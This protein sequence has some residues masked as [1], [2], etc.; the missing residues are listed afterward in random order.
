MAAASLLTI[1]ETSSTACSWAHLAIKSLASKPS[2]TNRT[3]SQPRQTTVLISGKSKTLSGV[4]SREV[5]KKFARSQVTTADSQTLMECATGISERRTSY[6]SQ[7]S[8]SRTICLLTVDYARTL[9]TSPQDLLKKL[10]LRKSVSKIFSV[11]IAKFAKYAPKGGARVARSTRTW[12]RLTSD[13]VLNIIL[14][15]KEY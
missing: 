15:M 3:T 13:H 5:G 11:Q 7:L 1:P 12:L 6:I 8:L 14:K 4:K 10:R 2:A 9:S